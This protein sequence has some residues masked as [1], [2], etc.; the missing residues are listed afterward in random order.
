VETIKRWKDSGYPIRFRVSDTPINIPVSIENFDA[1]EKGGDVGTVYYSIT[2]KQY[3]FI[4]IRQIETVT[5]NGVERLVVSNQGQR[6]SEAQNPSQYLVQEGDDIW[7]IS[8]RFGVNYEDLALLNNL[9]PPYTL[10]PNQV[11]RL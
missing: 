2:L 9:T 10:Q 8:R 5:Q 7:A 4:T 3:K 6:P 1:S 11:I